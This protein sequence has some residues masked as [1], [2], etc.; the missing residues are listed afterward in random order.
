MI[1][2]QILAEAIK[3][4]KTLIALDLNMC[5]IRNAH[6]ICLGE[7]IKTNTT[8]KALNLLM[9]PFHHLH[10]KSLLRLWLIP[11]QGYSVLE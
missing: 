7:A 5:N 3:Y 2:L 8:L 6:L 9:N 10:W 4:N 11:G 1:C